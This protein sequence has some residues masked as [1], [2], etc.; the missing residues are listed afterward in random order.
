VYH[1]TDLSCESRDTYCTESE[2]ADVRNCC[3][4]DQANNTNLM[5]FPCLSLTVPVLSID[6]CKSDVQTE[7]VR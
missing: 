3:N 4:I 6:V 7:Q 1:V 5:G 2:H